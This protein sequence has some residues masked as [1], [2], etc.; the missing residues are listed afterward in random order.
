MFFSSPVF[1]KGPA[2][3]LDIKD[4]HC[5]V[6][7][8]HSSLTLDDCFVQDSLNVLFDKESPVVKRSGF[9]VS[10]SSG[11]YAFTG[12]WPYTDSTNQ[13]WL[14]VRSSDAIMASPGSS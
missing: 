12:S 10:A 2:K 13:S 1:S 9:T 6:D 8:Y 7:T 4:F 3:Y 11:T 14:I 5:G